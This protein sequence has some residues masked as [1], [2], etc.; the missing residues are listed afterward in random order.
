MADETERLQ[1]LVESRVSDFE[2]GMR[3][4]ERRMA[5]MERSLSGD[6]GKVEQASRDAA[7]QMER[8][9][10]RATSRIEAQF[11]SVRNVARGAMAGLGGLGV[12]VGAFSVGAAVS[13]INRQTAAIAD[14]RAEAERAGLAFEDFQELKFAFE[15]ERVSIDALTDGFKELQL[16]ADEFITTG[17]GSGE[18]AFRRLGYGA[19]ELARKLED[20]KEL[21]FDILQRLQQ[22]DKAAQ[23]RIADEIFGGT[24]GEQFVQLLDAGEGKLRESI[25]R[26]HELG[27]VLSDEVGERAQDVNNAFNDL[28]A[29]IDGKVNTALTN[30][31]YWVLEIGRAIGTW[32]TA[33]ERFLSRL[34]NSSELGRFNQ[35]MI[36]NGFADTSGLTMLDPGLKA[37][38]TDA[39]NKRVADL[40]DELEAARAKV[41]DMATMDDAL[42]LAA[43]H[44]NVRRINDELERARKT[45]DDLTAPTTITVNGG[46]P[47]AAPT[48][49]PASSAITGTMGAHGQRLV[50][51]RSASGLTATVNAEH[52]AKFQGLIDDLEAQGYAIRSLG[53]YNNRTIA[54]TNKLSNHAFGNAIDI[55]PAENPMGPNLITDMPVNIAELARKH[56]LSWGGNWQSKKDAMHFEAPG[57]GSDSHTPTSRGTDKQVTD[58]DRQAEAIRRVNEQLAQEIEL[59]AQRAEMLANGFT[60]EQVNAALD[61]EALLRDQINQ[62]KSAGVQV[63]TQMEESLRRQVETLWQHREAAEAAATAQDGLA[64]A[65][66]DAASTAQ[67]IGQPILDT[68][69]SIGD[70]AE[71]ATE[72]FK[73]LAQQMAQ[74]VLQA[75]LF[76]GGPLGQFF[77]GGIFSGLGKRATGGSVTAGRPYLVGERGPELHIPDGNGRILDAARTR[78]MLNQSVAPRAASSGGGGV[79]YI[80]PVVQVHFDEKGL[81]STIREETAPMAERARSYTDAAFDN[82]A[83]AVPQMVDN[84]QRERELRRTRPNTSIRM[85]RLEGRNA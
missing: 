56:G 37:A 19:D 27:S 85:R 29:I 14:M 76:G 1:V 2:K 30:T 74:M 57:G 59:E 65:Q 40:T 82:L 64:Q 17:K 80:R 26:A 33:L 49:A 46:T 58:R 20:P 28:S 68:L 67:A 52:A 43:A 53:G 12:G 71:D 54:G 5:K 72:K 50:S 61:K 41:G 31:S 16:R 4:V 42:G 73:R 15:R 23:I 32:Q 18:E 70:G 36:R 22:F 3:S 44:E 45:L 83:N 24:G 6:L 21:F 51:I 84:R 77:G 13:A 25:A 78:S 35:W 63:D 55:N 7:R 48:A 60:V 8:D 39:A 79:R 75:A 62:L 38:A 81:R 9:F 11:A 69:M 10:D 47:A 34:G 66:Q